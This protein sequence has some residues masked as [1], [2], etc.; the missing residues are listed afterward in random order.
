MKRIGNGILTFGK[1]KVFEGIKGI[2]REKGKLI[3]WVVVGLVRDGH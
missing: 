3:M 1:R 2:K